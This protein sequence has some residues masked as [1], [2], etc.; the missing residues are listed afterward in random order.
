MISNVQ[1]ESVGSNLQAGFDPTDAVIR[2]YSK[3]HDGR[4]SISLLTL[5]TLL[6]PIN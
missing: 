3:F 6:T 2:Y 5:L 4:V 1:I